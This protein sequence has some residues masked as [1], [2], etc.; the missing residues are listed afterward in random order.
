ML[1]AMLGDQELRSALRAL[2]GVDEKGKELQKVKEKELQELKEKELQ[3]LK[4][5]VAAQEVLISQN[6]RLVDLE[7]Y[8]RRNCLNFTRIPENADESTTHLALDLR[9]DGRAKLERTEHRQDSSHRH[10]EN[11]APE[12]VT[13]TLSSHGREVR[14]LSDS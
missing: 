12:T 4:E 8:S 7:Q 14:V 6:E 2:F 11:S 9:E 13:P 5:R 10:A 3:E 1:L